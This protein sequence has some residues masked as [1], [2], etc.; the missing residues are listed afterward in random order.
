MRAAD[1]AIET[2]VGFA[3]GQH[4][5]KRA[6]KKLRRGGEATGSTL[7]RLRLGLPDPGA[8]TEFS[9]RPLDHGARILTLP[10]AN[11]RAPLKPL[12]KR[13]PESVHS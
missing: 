3:H 5:L 8:L 11:A 1:A 4:T 13:Q 2:G 6:G 10:M 12:R 9:V 7:L